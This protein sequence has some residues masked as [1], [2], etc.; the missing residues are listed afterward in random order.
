MSNNNTEFKPIPDEDKREIGE[1]E[2]D[3]FE[4]AHKLL[5][6]KMETNSKSNPIRASTHKFKSNKK[7][8]GNKTKFKL[9]MHLRQ[10][11][12]I[13]NIRDEAEYNTLRLALEGIP[14]RLLPAD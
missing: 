1:F 2:L 3:C 11:V 4:M 7:G 14:H 9:I 5:K 8:S 6:K 12:T 10:G 13:L